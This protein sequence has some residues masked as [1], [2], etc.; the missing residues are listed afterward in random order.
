MESSDF[1]QIYATI[2]IT[3]NKR[4]DLLYGLGDG[5][6]GGNDD[7]FE[8]P[9]LDRSKSLIEPEMMNS[10]CFNTCRKDPSIPRHIL[11]YVLVNCPLLQF[12][13]VECSGREYKIRLSSSPKKKQ[14]TTHQI[15]IGPPI[16]TSQAYLRCI[17]LEGFPSTQEDLDLIS[18]YLPNVEV[19]IIADDTSNS[20]YNDA[21]QPNNFNFNLTAFHKLKSF[22]INIAAVGD[23]GQSAKKAFDDLFLHFKFSDGEEAFYQICKEDRTYHLAITTQQFIMDNSQNENLLT[24]IFT[25]ECNNKLQESVCSYICYIGGSGVGKIETAPKNANYKS[26]D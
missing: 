14:S 4:M 10:W 17:R 13:R 5:I 9:Y 22:R 25:F 18:S 19:V 3:N 8:M 16:V 6:F 2:R 26:F 11:K 21:H 1:R 12:L 20:I 15:K 24:K 23:F 7:A